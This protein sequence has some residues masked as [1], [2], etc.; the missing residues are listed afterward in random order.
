MN[1]PLNRM[2]NAVTFPF[3]TRS[4]YPNSLFAVAT[5]LAGTI[6]AS[7]GGLAPGSFSADSR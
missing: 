6:I 5:A 7:P 3:A 2:A 4:P 1:Q